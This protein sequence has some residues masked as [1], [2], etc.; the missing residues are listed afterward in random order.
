[1]ELTTVGGWGSSARANCLCQRL[2][3]VTA[4]LSFLFCNRWGR[5]VVKN[6]E[7]EFIELLDG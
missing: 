5:C 7:S 4:H 6:V 3:Q 2:E 1:M